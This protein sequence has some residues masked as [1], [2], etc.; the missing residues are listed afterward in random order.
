MTTVAAA[1]LLA[2]A[3]AG[4]QPAPNIRRLPDSAAAMSE[5]LRHARALVAALDLA[6]LALE[7]HDSAGLVAAA[8][9]VAAHPARALEGTRSQRR[10]PAVPPAAPRGGVLTPDT[11][12]LLRAA[13]RLGAEPPLPGDTAPTF[14]PLPSLPPSAPDDT[15][16]AQLAVRAIAERSVDTWRIERS[17][18]SAA[19]LYVRGD[20]GT[21]LDC[22]VYDD[23]W[24]V[25][26]T[27]ASPGDRCFFPLIPRRAGAFHLQIRNRG[28]Q[29][30]TYV[31]IAG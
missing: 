29:A 22:V 16:R 15:L 6:R 8:R 11:A 3:T 1:L 24:R 2:P 7:Q 31:I 4:G 12:A 30:N 25:V 23:R 14:I 17:A 21:D 27:D 5:S 26:A 28:G 19:E 13:R 18:G 20:G 9:I 10:A